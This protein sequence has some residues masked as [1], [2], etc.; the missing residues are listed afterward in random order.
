MDE[1]KRQP[2]AVASQTRPQHRRTPLLVRSSE[3]PIRHWRDQ[4]ACPQVQRP[5]MSPY[6]PN[7]ASGRRR[8][9]RTTDAIQLGVGNTCL[10]FPTYPRKRCR[11]PVLHRLKVAVSVVLL[12]L[13]TGAAN[14]FCSVA[15]RETTRWNLIQFGSTAQPSPPFLCTNRPCQAQAS[16]TPLPA[17]APWKW[18]WHHIRRIHFSRDSM[19]RRGA[20]SS[21]AGAWDAHS[22]LSFRRWPVGSLGFPTPNGLATGLARRSMLSSKAMVKHYGNHG[23]QQRS[24]SMKPAGTASSQSLDWSVSSSVS[25]ATRNME[26]RIS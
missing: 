1:D 3:R 20:L 19:D 10:N 24:T 22:L 7:C 14:D 4:D 2:R 26:A 16:G 23:R 13:E 5:L 21:P 17:H 12:D 8:R 18:I 15:L 9:I 25:D 11:L 6:V